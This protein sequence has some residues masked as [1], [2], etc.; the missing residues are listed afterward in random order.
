VDGDIDVDNPEE[1]E[2]A[3]ATRLQASRGVVIIRD[4]RL[5]SLDPSAQ[6]GVGDKLGIDATVPIKDREKY[7]R[8]RIPG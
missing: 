3:L 1:V 5:S 2:W 4:A 6:D 8:A 7:R